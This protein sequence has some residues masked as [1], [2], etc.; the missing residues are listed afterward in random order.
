MKLTCDR[1]RF[2]QIFS[3]VAT[4]VP[5]RDIKPILQNVKMIVTDN[6]VLL[7]ATD[8][9]I[10]IRAEL[11][12][13]ILIEEPGEAMLPTKLLLKILQES[14]D[15]QLTIES[16]EEKTTISGTNS[17]FQLQTPFASD[18]PNIE[19]FD[20]NAYHLVASSAMRDLLRRA[21][22]AI[23]TESTRYALSGVL[24]EF[25]D[26]Q[27]ASI[28]TDGRRLTHQVAQA[29]TVEGH[30]SENST[31]FPLGALLLLDK[32]MN[33]TEKVKVS[34]QENKVLFE[35]GP[36][37][38][39]AQLVQG[40][41]P[42]WRGIV[43]DSAGK[44]Q[45]DLIV[46]TLASAVRQARIVTQEKEPAVVFHFDKGVLEVSAQSSEVG[47][48]QIKI[49]IAF[50]GEPQTIKCDPRFILEFLSVLESDRI[51]SLFFAGTQPLLFTTN[52]G[53]K[54]V[55]MPLM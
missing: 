27:V 23:D 55:L 6:E 26:Q 28:A 54:Y 38:I 22:F 30:T 39:H 12:E 31:I 47:Q 53:Y 42:K 2:S 1:D 17:Y 20:Q 19:R 35:S 21:K 33:D 44:N 32:A 37:T 16:N 45:V 34:V 3:L 8:N 29:E 13:S 51:V 43:P 48:S 9:E 24:F 49:P 14:T 4:V 11:C 25:T 15:K 50:E 46:G 5:K 18:Y 7:M 52:D 40:R 41:F 36:F 10:S